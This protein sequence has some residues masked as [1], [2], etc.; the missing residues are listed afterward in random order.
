LRITR[1][2]SAST[3]WA[4]WQDLPVY[5]IVARDHHRIH[6]PPWQPSAPNADKYRDEFLE[7]DLVVDDVDALYGE[8]ASCGV[9][10]TRALADMH[11]VR[12][13]LSRRTVMAAYSPSARIRNSTFTESLAMTDPTAVRIRSD[14]HRTGDLLADRKTVGVDD[15]TEVIPS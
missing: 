2:D 11:R 15:E 4:K 13:N 5:A 6:F 10:F 7:A 14:K 9:E 12:A 1:K 8:Y 3:A